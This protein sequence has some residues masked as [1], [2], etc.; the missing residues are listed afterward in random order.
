MKRDVVLD[1]M[2]ELNLEELGIKGCGIRKVKLISERVD[3][4]ILRSY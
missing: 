2:I 3:L 1:K 4:S